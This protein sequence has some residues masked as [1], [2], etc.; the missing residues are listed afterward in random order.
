MFDDLLFIE[1]NP[2]PVKAA[3]HLMGKIENE[4]RPPLY[5]LAG[6]NLEKLRKELVRLGL[7]S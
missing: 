5:P 3:L 7:V 2:I 6:P 4:I 1:S